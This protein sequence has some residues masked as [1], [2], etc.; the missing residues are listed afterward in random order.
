MRLLVA[1]PD[2]DDAGIVL[3]ELAHSFP[4]E[5]THPREIAHAVVRL[6]GGGDARHEIK[7]GR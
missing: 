2:L 7:Q 4:A 5:T 3:D 1:H 6:E